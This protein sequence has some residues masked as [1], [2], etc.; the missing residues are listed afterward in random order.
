MNIVCQQSGALKYIY[1][2]GD[3]VLPDWR[4]LAFVMGAHIPKRCLV[5]RGVIDSHS[6]KLDSRI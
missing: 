6:E 1:W 5:Q 3:R 2:S 4:P